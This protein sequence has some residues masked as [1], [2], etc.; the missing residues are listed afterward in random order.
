MFSSKP[1]VIEAEATP[2]RFIGGCEETGSGRFSP[3]PVSLFCGGAKSSAGPSR[4]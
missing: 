1:D 3:E 2:S 4:G